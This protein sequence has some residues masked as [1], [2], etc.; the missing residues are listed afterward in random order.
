VA[1]TKQRPG[2][3]PSI[4]ATAR[5][6]YDAIVGLT[7]AFCR[8]HLTE[9]YEAMCRKLAGVL[10]RKRPSTLLRRIQENNSSGLGGGMTTDHFSKPGRR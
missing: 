7:D 2:K 3:E 6:A 4:P 1:R 8:E 10:A 9:E 5:P